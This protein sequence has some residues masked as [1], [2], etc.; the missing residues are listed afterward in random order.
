MIITTGPVLQV[1]MP[2]ISAALRAENTSLREMER[3]HI[4]AIL[5]TTD[6]RVRGKNGAAEILGLKPTTLEARMRK[7]DIQRK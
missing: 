1:E 2:Q 7:L 6:W 4:L 3:K 5:K